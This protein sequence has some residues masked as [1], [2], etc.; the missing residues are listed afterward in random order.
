MQNAIIKNIFSAEEISQ[1]L[2]N[3]D[4]KTNE[5]KVN[6]QNVVKFSIELS[7]Q[8]KTTLENKL[9]IDLA[10][11]TTLP[12]RWIKGD[13]MPHIDKGESA[14][15]DTYLVYL[16]DSVGN[17]IIDDVT[18]PISAGD[19]HIFSEGLAHSTINTGNTEARLMLGPMSEMGFPVGASP[20]VSYYFDTLGNVT[21]AFSSLGAPGDATSS[22]GYLDTS[23]NIV[24]T[25]SSISQWIIYD[26]SG[27][28]G[29]D[30]NGTIVSATE[31]LNG[32][33]GYYYLYPYVAPPPPAVSNICFRAGTPITT[34]QG[35][36]AIEEI[37]IKKHTIRQKQIKAITKTVSR[38]KY[39]VCFAKDSFGP[40]VPCEKTVMSKNHL[41]WYNGQMHKAKE[42][43]EGVT[44]LKKEKKVTTV[45]YNGEILYN[46]LLETYEK[47]L[48]NNLICETLHPDNK[49]AELYTFLAQYN[50]KE[51][52]EIIKKYNTIV[53]KHKM[54]L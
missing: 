34:D 25:F 41:V 52:S 5:L 38:D 6:E 37:D 22:T 40:N 31:F 27:I 53:V 39:L 18:Y 45:K 2:N 49:I 47:M 29:E 50:V 11:T 21:N 3:P 46:V 14:F 44:E 9:S 8:L 23:G 1:I 48:V 42:F 13:T 24:I 15:T 32:F 20:A 10:H 28:T 30:A 19:A 36:V 51:H 35:I 16:T 26:S 4:V 17:L 7:A 54:Y 33:G 12:M 43:V